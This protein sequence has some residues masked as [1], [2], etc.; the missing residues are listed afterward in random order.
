MT[1]TKAEEQVMNYLWQ[2]EKAFFK[3]LKAQFPEPKPATTT[4]NTLLKRL[5][6]KGFV[7]YKVYG[8]SRE[9]FPVVPKN[10]YY[11]TQIKGLIKNSFNNSI[12]Q[13]AS[14]FTKETDLSEKQLK[15]LRDIIDQ[16]IKSSSND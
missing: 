11:S 7:H 9:Y 2:L 6:D 13:F 3:E 5:I 12:E 1:L 10:E 16:Q 14:F 4:I 8:N 15:S